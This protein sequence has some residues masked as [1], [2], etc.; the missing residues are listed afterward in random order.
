MKLEF[1]ENEQVELQ[2]QGSHLKSFLNVI[3]GTFYLTNERIIFA[4][5]NKAVRFWIPEAAGFITGT[6]AIFAHPY[7]Q[8]VSAVIKK[9]GFAKKTT[10]TFQSGES[11]DVQA[12]DH[13]KFMTTLRNLV[14]AANGDNVRDDGNGNFSVVH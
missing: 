9:H 1:A 2:V 5:P 13:D 11:Y 4:R 8:L 6:D 12:M 3:Q 10:I 7:T 14:I